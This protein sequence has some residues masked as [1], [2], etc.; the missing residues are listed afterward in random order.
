MRFINTDT[1]I[2][3]NI[4]TIRRSE[5]PTEPTSL[6]QVHPEHQHIND[7]I[8]VPVTQTLAAK[9]DTNDV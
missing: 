3:S 1:N 2:P 4:E 7:I 5:H 8:R 9:R 6:P